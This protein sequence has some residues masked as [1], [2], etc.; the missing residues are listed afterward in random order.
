MT[1]GAPAAR[2]WPAIRVRRWTR[3]PWA[4]WTLVLIATKPLADVL[5]ERTLADRLDPGVAWAATS[6][7]LLAGWAL[8][9][10]RTSIDATL[11]T[12]TWLALAALAAFA[13]VR[14]AGLPA[15]VEAGKVLAGLAP[16]VILVGSRNPDLQRLRWPLAA[17]AAGAAIHV[18]VAWLQAAGYVDTTYTQSSLGRTIGRPSGL[19]YHPVTLAYHLVFVVLVTGLLERRGLV[20]PGVALPVMAVAVLSVFV[21]THRMGAVAVL[22]ALAAWA[23]V[24]L[25]PRRAV[26]RRALLAVGIAVLVALG[27]GVTGSGAWSEAADRLWGGVAGVLREGDLDPTSDR[28]LRGRGRIWAGAADLVATAEPVRRWAGY[29]V[30]VV[31]PHTDYL[32]LPLVHGVVGSGLILAFL[33]LVGVASGRR[34]D[35]TGV[36]YVLVAFGLLGL[37]ALTTKPTSYTSFMWLWSV[38]V[39]LAAATSVRRSRGAA[40]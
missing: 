2:R 4:L 13:T 37:Y 32:R 34:C 5:S 8:T 24:R 27:V 30:Q 22:L 28:F 16:I 29:G 7:L 6:L 3:P 18:A 33:A 17:F 9:R 31:D 26:S 35:P 38:A 19:F 10:R 40:A 11:L 14:I 20:R 1:V 21:S 39:W 12:L 23:V 36:W 25:A 15:A